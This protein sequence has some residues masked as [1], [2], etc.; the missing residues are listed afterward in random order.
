MGEIPARLTEIDTAKTIICMCHSGIRSAQVAQF[1][2]AQGYSKAIN[3]TGGIHAW[4]ELVN[5]SI[6]KY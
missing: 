6:A 1:L 2:V 3:L 5:S 4:S